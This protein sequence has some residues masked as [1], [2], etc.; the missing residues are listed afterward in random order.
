MRA[1]YVK[2]EGM[3][4]AD[5][6]PRCVGLPDRFLPVRL[7]S[8]LPCMP[9]YSEWPQWLQL[10]VMVPH[11]ILLCVLA[12]LWWPRSDEGRRTAVFAFLYLAAVL[13]VLHLCS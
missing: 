1:F 9:K 7:C 11:G 5:P 12:W 8:R 4:V 10:L 3:L 6:Y 2:H 13:P